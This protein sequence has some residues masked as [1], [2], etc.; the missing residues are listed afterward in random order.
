MLKKLIQA[1][2]YRTLRLLIGKT[3]VVANVDVYGGAFVTEPPGAAI[4][5]H[6]SVIDGCGIMGDGS[7]V[8]RQN[9]SQVIRKWDG[10]EQR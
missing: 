5:F 8:T 2:R 9:A 6:N 10:L 1:I 4:H 7:G 3:P